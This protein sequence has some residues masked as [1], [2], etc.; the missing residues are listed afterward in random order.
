[1]FIIFAWP[2]NIIGFEGNGV[3]STHIVHDSSSMSNSLNAGVNL[4]KLQL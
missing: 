4:Y 3:I 2:F 1:M